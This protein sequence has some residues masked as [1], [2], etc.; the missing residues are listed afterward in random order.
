M[1]ERIRR[2]IKLLPLRVDPDLIGKLRRAEIERD[3]WKRILGTLVRLSRDDINYYYP[4][5]V[6]MSPIFDDAKA[7]KEGAENL[8]LL[9]IKIDALPYNPFWPSDKD[10]YHKAIVELTSLS[11]QLKVLIIEYSRQI[12]SEIHTYGVQMGGE[13]FT[14]MDKST[15]EALKMKGQG[16]AVEVFNKDI[17]RTK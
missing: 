16:N 15:I 5:D 8:K 11:K 7:E 6:L 17:S 10:D 12:R 13:I 4:F 9:K 2:G 3:K 1:H 14:F